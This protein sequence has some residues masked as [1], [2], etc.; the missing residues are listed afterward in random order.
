[1]SIGFGVLT[2]LVPT[3]FAL[4]TAVLCGG[5]GIGQILSGRGLT[6]GVSNSVPSILVICRGVIR[7]V[8]SGNLRWSGV[9]HVC[10]GLMVQNMSRAGSE[11]YPIQPQFEHIGVVVS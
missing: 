1:M 7:G 10:S 5:R 8:C 9:R 2:L 4:V 3:I 6:F 11:R